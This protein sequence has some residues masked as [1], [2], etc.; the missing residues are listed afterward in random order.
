[1]LYDI[2]H[3]IITTQTAKTLINLIIK[4]LLMKHTSNT[5]AKNAQINDCFDFAYRAVQA[6][7]LKMADCLAKN[8]TVQYGTHAA[9]RLELLAAMR[10]GV[11]AQ[12]SADVS[13][14]YDKALT[15]F[16]IA[17][18]GRAAQKSADVSGGFASYLSNFK[19]VIVVSTLPAAVGYVNDCLNSYAA[20]LRRRLLH[21][22]DVNG[23]VIIALLAA[24][25]LAA[26]Y[27][28]TNMDALSLIIGYSNTA[29]FNTKTLSMLIRRARCYVDVI[30]CDLDAA[31]ARSS[32]MANYTTTVF[33]AI[34]FD[35]AGCGAVMDNSTNTVF[36]AI[37]FNAAG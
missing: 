34:N 23:D 1:M 8:D 9:A 32:A 18:G 10:G 37:N 5:A 20:P 21:T 17:L 22:M 3:T 15:D 2:Y 12:K 24:D 13:G 16:A 11:A 36:E 27:K 35:A 29:G 28:I 25:R 4:D 26:I 7:N 30:Q 33:E 6:L 31:A 19:D 14:A